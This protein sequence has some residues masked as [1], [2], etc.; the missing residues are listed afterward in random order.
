[1]FQNHLQA[2]LISSHSKLV[3]T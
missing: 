3:C 2:Y 1:M